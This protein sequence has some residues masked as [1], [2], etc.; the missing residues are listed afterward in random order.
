MSL[1]RRRRAAEQDVEDVEDLRDVGGVEDTG[2]VT[3]EEDDEAGED[4]AEAAAPAAKRAPRDTAAK[5]H[6]KDDAR[7]DEDARP[8]RSP[9][10]RTADGDGPYDVEDAP[11]DGRDRFDLG[12]LRI[13]VGADV[14]VRMQANEQ[15]QVADVVLIAGQNA[16]QIAVF[17]A[18]RSE[19]IWDEIREELREGITGDGGTVT[20]QDGEYGVELR[21]R[22]G[23]P[24]GPTDL[25]FVGIDGPR[26]FVR[27]LFQGRVATDPSAAPALMESLHG[28]IVDR[29][30]EAMPVRDPL[31]LTL[32][33]EAVRQ[34]G[35]PAGD[36]D[37]DAAEGANGR[38]ADGS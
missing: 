7:L 17:A 1:F 27:A 26:W 8:A 13:P 14:E 37:G 5:R 35:Q 25:R 29:G 20:E 23:T 16:L 12:S 11:D 24:D 4:D 30:K 31:P 15:G 18:P 28:L 3:A 6:P 19:G 22:V 38:R 33:P 2:A 9:R 34:D 21:A 32:P 10:R 36:G